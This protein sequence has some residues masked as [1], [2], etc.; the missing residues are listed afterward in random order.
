MRF[1]RQLN[2]QLDIAAIS[3][4]SPPA[5]DWLKKTN[6]KGSWTRQACASR[7]EEDKITRKGR[8]SLAAGGSGGGRVEAHKLKLVGNITGKLTRAVRSTQEAAKGLE[9]QN[10]NQMCGTGKSR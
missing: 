1:R 3:P 9:W 2:L 10:Q 7:S 8:G 6:G 4:F 5:V